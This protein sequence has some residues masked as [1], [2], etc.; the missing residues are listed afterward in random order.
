MGSS[1]AKQAKKLL[2]AFEKVSENREELPAPEEK[3]GE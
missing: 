2:K 3:E 1:K